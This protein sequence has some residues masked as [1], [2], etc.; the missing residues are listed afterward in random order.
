MQNL[1]PGHTVQHYTQHCVQLESCTVYTPLKLLCT[2][3]RATVA[4]VESAP[5]SATSCAAVSRCVHHLQH[6]AQF[7][8]TRGP[9]LETPDNFPGALSI[10][11]ELIYLSANGNYWRKLSDRLFSK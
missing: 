5:T 1:R 6:C 3:L 7:N 9:L 4:E 11:F 10:F 2:T 8:P